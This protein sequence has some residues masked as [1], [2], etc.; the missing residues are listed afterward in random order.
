[1]PASMGDGTQ[2]DLTDE[3][4]PGLGGF[5]EAG[6]IEPGVADAYEEQSAVPTAPADLNDEPA[7]DGPLNPA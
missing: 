1:M 2:H 6:T 3:P 4:G 7:I 5:S